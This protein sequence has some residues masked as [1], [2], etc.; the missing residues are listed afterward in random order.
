MELFANVVS[1]SRVLV[2]EFLH[3]PIYSSQVSGG[4]TLDKHL[5]ERKFDYYFESRT[6]NLQQL[7]CLF[8]YDILRICLT[9]PYLFLFN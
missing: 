5:L 2:H 8:S 6:V 4:T 1:G 9:S 3:V 7:L